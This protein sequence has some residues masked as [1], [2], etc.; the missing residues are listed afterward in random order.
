MMKKFSKAVVTTTL[1]SGLVLGI[2][3]AAAGMT[4]NTS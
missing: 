4:V 1:T 2:A 3:T